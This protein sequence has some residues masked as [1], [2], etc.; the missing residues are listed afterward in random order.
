M[1]SISNIKIGDVIYPVTLSGGT[2]CVLAKM[3]V[4]N[5]EVAF[6]YLIRETGHYHSALIPK[7]VAIEHKYHKGGTYFAL[8]NGE[9]INDKNDLDENTKIFSLND[10]KEVPY[11]FH[12]LPQTCCAALAATSQHGTLIKERPL[13]IEMLRDLK[14]GLTKSKEKSLKLDKK[15]IPN[16]IS[17]SG[18]IRRMSNYTQKIFETAFVN[19][20]N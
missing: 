13:P 5:I 7:G 15:G 12:Q 3:P 1:P 11:K 8:F 9:F 6:D 16:V 2:L 17:L 19:D 14:F 4:E 20:N 10:W 18:F